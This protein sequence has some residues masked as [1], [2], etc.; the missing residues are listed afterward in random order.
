[1]QLGQFAGDADLAFGQQLRQIGRG[2][3]DAVAGLVE[4]QGPRIRRQRLQTLATRPGLGRQETLEG[5]AV[6][7]Q[8]ADRQRGHGC[9]G[10]GNRDHR[11]AGAACGAHQNE[12]RIG[13]Q[14]RAGV[15]DQ[16]QRLTVPQLFDQ[17]L[18]ELAFVVF[19]QRDHRPADSEVAQQLLAGPRV[20]GTDAIHR[21]EHLLRPR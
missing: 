12:A 11:N 20:F 16:R 18:A 1:M 17:A 7:R 9:A 2:V 8:S 10:A 21:L 19:M 5:E 4:D 15:G 13:D 6:A 3:G 14:R